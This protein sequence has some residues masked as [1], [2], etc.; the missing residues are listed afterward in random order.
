[1]EARNEEEEEKLDAKT[2]EEEEKN[3][4]QFGSLEKWS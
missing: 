3:K 2:R 1:M 4:R